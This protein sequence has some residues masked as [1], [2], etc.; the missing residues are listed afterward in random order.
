M[1]TAVTSLPLEGPTPVSARV[2]AAPVRWLKQAGAALS[3]AY[4]ASGRVRAE[5]QL[6]EFAERCEAT[7]PELAKEL[8]LACGQDRMD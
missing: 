1:N 3:E 4:I 7:Q 5:R 2:V 6:L 8:R